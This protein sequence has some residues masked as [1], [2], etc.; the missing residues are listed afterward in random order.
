MND[1]VKVCKKHGELCIDNVY[2]CK[3]KIGNICYKCA[4]CTKEK[5]TE[6]RKKG[7]F[8]KYYSEHRDYINKYQKEYSKNIKQDEDFK[9]RRRFYSKRYRTKNAESLKMRK[10]IKLKEKVKNLD[11]VYIRKVIKNKKL[12]YLS[13]NIYFID[14]MRQMLK[15]KRY[16]RENK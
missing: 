5:T 7:Y 8:K 15:I 3:T 9:K 1:I 14:F 11:D 10:S 16:I 4:L 2:S 12:H 13:T 6:L